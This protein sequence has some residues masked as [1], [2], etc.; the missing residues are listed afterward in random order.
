MYLDRCADRSFAVVGP[1]FEG[2]R[3][4]LVVLTLKARSDKAGGR[5]HGEHEHDLQAVWVP[6]HQRAAAREGLPAAGRAWARQL[7]LP[8]LGGEPAW[9]RRTGPPGRLP[10]TGRRPPGPRRKW[11]AAT[12]EER[13]ARSWTVERW[14]RYWLST[15]THL[16]PTSLLHYTRDV[17]QVLI[18][19]LGTLCLAD[20][21]APR[22]RA[23]FTEIAQTT[24]RRNQPQSAAAMQHL[25]TTLRAALNLAVREG[26]IESNPGPAHRGH[27]LPPPARAGLDRRPRPG[28]ADHRA[29]PSR[30]S[31]DRRTPR[32]LPHRRGR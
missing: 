22:L 4:S 28:M 15:R 18:P 11:L 27:R 25:R 26:V 13:T 20:L 6:G 1:S 3:S 2:P 16:R 24:N 7:V 5:D 17:E 8:R 10:V 14:L 30:S 29:A 12:G 9:P 19:W 21:D 31:V 32:H 23:A